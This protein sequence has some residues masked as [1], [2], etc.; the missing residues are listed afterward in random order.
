MCFSQ[1][2]GSGA[3]V[4]SL[5]AASRLVPALVVLALKGIGAGK[6]LGLKV[7]YFTDPFSFI[8]W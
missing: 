2:Y 7:H 5:R 4:Q 8:S 6:V 3:R 1:H